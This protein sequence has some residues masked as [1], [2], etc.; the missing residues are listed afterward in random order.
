M[1]NC[2]QELKN[3]RKR[4]EDPSHWCQGYLARDVDKRPVHPHDKEAVCWCLMGAEVF[5]RVCHQSQLL[6]RQAVTHFQHGW[7]V[8][9]FN[10]LSTHE[11]VLKAIDKAIE[12]AEKDAQGQ[13]S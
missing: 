13:Q 5:E 9:A 11:T 10:D 4:L 6:L 8:L 3:L 12:F 1:N 7:S 2:V